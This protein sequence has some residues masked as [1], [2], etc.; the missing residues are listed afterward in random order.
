MAAPFQDPDAAYNSIFFGKATAAT[1]GAGYFSGGGRYRF[2]YPGP[3]TTFEFSNE[4]VI[5]SQ[6]IAYVKADFTHVTDGESLYQKICVPSPTS[7]SSASTTP[8]IVSAPVT[9]TPTA[10]IQNEPRAAEPTVPGYPDPIYISSDMVVSGY[11]LNGSSYD[12]VAVLSVLSFEPNS[13]AEFQDLV[14]GFL[15]EAKSRG[16]T[17]IIVDL[18]SNGG[19]YI[20]QGYDLYRQFFPHTLQDGFTRFRE[21]DAFSTCAEIISN[22]IPPNYDPSTA[23]VQLIYDYENPSNYRYDLDIHDRPFPSFDRKFKPHTFKGDKFTSIVRWNL[24][25]PLTTIN[26]TFGL[27]IEITGYG[28]RQNFTQLFAAEDII[29]VCQFTIELFVKNCITI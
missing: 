7:I 19:G 26:T 10:S 24:N 22:E 1:F 25:D 21:N 29:M 28:T 5:T 17:K 6:N 9:A 20:L 14:Q 13:P 4:T 18:S 2:I 8:S 11:F 15:S 3:N 27:G 23:P 12:D 16:K